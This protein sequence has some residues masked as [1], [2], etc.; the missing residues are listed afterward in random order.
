M[1]NVAFKLK[2]KD[3]LLLVLAAE[4]EAKPI[5]T[6][7]VSDDLVQSNK[8]SAKALI[9]EISPLIKGAGGGQE[10]FATAGGSNPKGI[11]EALGKIKLLIT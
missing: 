7:M 11:Q 9:N 1:K 5:I 10:H 3:N 8:L 4:T 2:Q 6:I